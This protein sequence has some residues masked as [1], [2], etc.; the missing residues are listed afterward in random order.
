M[1]Y[2]WSEAKTVHLRFSTM[3]KLRLK[4]AFG[5]QNLMQKQCICDLAIMLIG[6]LELRFK[7]LC[8]HHRFRIKV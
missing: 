4:I 8:A 3:E 7:A 5:H 6:D 2:R 1:K